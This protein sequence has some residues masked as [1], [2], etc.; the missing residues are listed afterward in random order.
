MLVIEGADN[1]GKTTAAK[2]LV[3]I[4]A[5]QCVYPIRYQ[6]MGRP[7]DVF[8]FF[9]DYRDMLS[10]YAVQD[11]FHLGALIWHENVITPGKF[12]L[13]ESWMAALGSYTVLFISDCK[14]W[15]AK[16]IETSKRKE[17]FD[18]NK[19]LSAN[20]Q[21]AKMAY[22]GDSRFKPRIDKVFVV[23]CKDD[24]PTDLQL[25]GVLEEWYERME[26]LERF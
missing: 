4:A 26:P 1:L 7:N 21:Y 10:M 19:I 18:V 13:L 20:L 11:R 25:A 24:F 15:Y 9:K 23:D 2:R 6:H 12:K 8:D 14:K 3:E 5:K 16:R 22:L 17:M